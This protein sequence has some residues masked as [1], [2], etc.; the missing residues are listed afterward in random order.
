MKIWTIFLPVFFSVIFLPVHA[1][2]YFY[3]RIGFGANENFF[4]DDV[5]WEDQDEFAGHLG[6]GYRARLSDRWYLDAHWSHYS[7]WL[8]GP[9]F[10]DR[11]ESSLD[12][13]GMAL[14]YRF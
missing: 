5:I 8:A 14:E 12:H 3:A 7:Q 9:P 1:E 11:P 13:V 10:D 2:S 6:L 4:T